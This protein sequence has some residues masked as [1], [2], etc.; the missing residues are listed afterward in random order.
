MAAPAGQLRSAGGG[1]ETPIE[2]PQ[3]GQCPQPQLLRPGLGSYRCACSTLGERN[4]VWG[5]GWGCEEMRRVLGDVP[6]CPTLSCHPGKRA[7]SKDPEVA[8]S[9]YCAPRAHGPERPAST[10][11]AALALGE[12]HGKV[13]KVKEAIQKKG[14][15]PAEKNKG[16]SDLFQGTSFP[17]SQSLTSRE[18]YSGKPVSETSGRPER[19][20]EPPERASRPDHD[21]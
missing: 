17:V 13:G 15:D 7:G 1:T 4:G 8:H 11:S 18:R 2:W 20:L 21:T 6:G 19:K 9:V 5:G 12:G 16:R 10:R 14:Q 3:R